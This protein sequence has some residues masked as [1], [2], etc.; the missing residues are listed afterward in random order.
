MNVPV[1]L[2]EG[3]QLEHR[4]EVAKLRM[5]LV[6]YRE[7]LME[8]GIEPPDRD[9]DELLD[10]Y[11]RCCAVI[12]TASELAAGLGSAKEMLQDWSR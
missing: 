2:L 1:E 3:V 4:A 12:S 8:N 10:L 6:I 7:R 5:Q 9:S 11:R